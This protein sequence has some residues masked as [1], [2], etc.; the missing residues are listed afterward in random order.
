MFRSKYIIL[1]VILLVA[2]SCSKQNDRFRLEAQFKNLNQGEF[3]IYNVY[4]GEKDTVAVN[5]GRFIYDRPLTDTLTLAIL[6]PNYSE[7]PVFATPGGEVK[8]E[9][10]ATHL[11]ETELT[12]TPDNDLM[13]AFRLKTNEMTPPEAEKEAEQFINDHPE[14]PASLYLLHKYFLQSM[15]PDYAK[16]HT[17][18]EKLRTH[19]PNNPNVARLLTQTETLKDYVTSGK[20]PHFQTISTDGDT[21]TEAS[22]KGDVNVIMAWATWSYD[23]QS[24]M[25]T[26]STLRKKHGQRLKVLSICLDAAP[27]EGK[28]VL[29]RDSIQ[30]PNVCDSLMWQSPVLTQLGIATIPANIVT[31]KQGTIVA[32]NLSSNDLQKKVKEM[33]GE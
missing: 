27:S 12:G 29:E 33:L 17:L 7:I 20:L 13:T 31:D 18:C 6:F 25:R 8:M 22:M 2:S 28:G 1:A 15:E 4:T 26:L 3:Y 10:D 30:W 9:G 16:C 23:S 11:R 19:Q 24:P 21:V 5:D 32:R 14:S